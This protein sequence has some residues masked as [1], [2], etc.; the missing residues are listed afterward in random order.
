M[1]APTTEQVREVVAKLKELKPRIRQFTYFGDDNRAA[2]QAQIDVLERGMDE[3]EVYDRWDDGERDMHVRNSALSAL[4]WYETGEIEDA[5]GEND[6]AEGWESLV[7][8]PKDA[9]D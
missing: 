7:A 5:D 6:L 4:Q 8:E 2:I 3:D 9:N 1:E